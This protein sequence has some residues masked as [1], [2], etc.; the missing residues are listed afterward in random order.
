VIRYDERGCGLSDWNAADLSY[1]R[2]RVDR[3]GGAD[4]R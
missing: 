4:G 2:G 1:E 3:N